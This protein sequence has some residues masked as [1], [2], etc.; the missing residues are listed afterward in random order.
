MGSGC[1]QVTFPPQKNL[2]ISWT[3]FGLIL[4]KYPW[5]HLNKLKHPEHSPPNT[6]WEAEELCETY[7]PTE[8]RINRQD[9]L[10]MI[11]CSYLYLWV[12]ILSMPGLS[13]F[14]FIIF[15]LLETEEQKSIAECWH[16]TE[17]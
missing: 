13:P 2:I 4:E 1:L 15:P 16:H 3:D 7:W 10:H 5:L 11:N 12:W 6:G 17:N 14:S 9:R 8:Y